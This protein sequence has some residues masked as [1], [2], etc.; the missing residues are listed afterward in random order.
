M[1]REDGSFSGQGQRH[2]WLRYLALTPFAVGAALFSMF[3]FTVVILLFFV[4]MLGFGMRIW[5]LRRKMRSAAAAA[6][7]R[8]DQPLEGEF[9]VVRENDVGDEI[10]P[11]RRVRR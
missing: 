8:P 3:F 4:A 10:D 9:T 1:N 11:V 6:P 2:P 5:W 7:R